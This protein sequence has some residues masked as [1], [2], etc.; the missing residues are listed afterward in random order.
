[1]IDTLAEAARRITDAHLPVVD[2]RHEHLLVWIR[3]AA[4]LI[5][6]RGCSSA[7]PARRCEQRA[8]DAQQSG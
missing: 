1:L 2:S 7:S 6:H 8:G 3:P 5:E 4:V